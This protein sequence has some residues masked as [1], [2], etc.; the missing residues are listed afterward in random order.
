[1]Y[2]PEICKTKNADIK[3][4]M[5]FSLL[6]FKG[7]YCW[8]V[9]MIFVVILPICYLL[10]KCISPVERNAKFYSEQIISKKETK[11]GN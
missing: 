6:L 11:F 10:P 4:L 5:R 9:I 2:I 8:S 7:W 3:M 1:M